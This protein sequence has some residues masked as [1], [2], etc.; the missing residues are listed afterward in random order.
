MNPLKKY[1]VVIGFS[2]I[3]AVL[4]AHGQS[5]QSDGPRIT[6]S[7]VI[8]TADEYARVKWYMGERN[9][10]GRGESSRFL[11]EYPVG[12]RTGVG[13]KWGGWDDVETFLED[14]KQGKGTGTGGYVDYQVYPMDSVS[15][16]SCTGL[17]S[18]A[19]HLEHKYTLT[20][21]NAP[22]VPRQMHEISHPIS[23]VD[24]II[25]KTDMLRKGDA[26]MNAYHIILFVYETRNGKV[27]IMD[28][29][30]SGAGFRE[31][32]WMALSQDGYSAIRYNGIEE[33][34]DPQGSAENPYS[35]DSN[36]FPFQHEGNTR[37][38]VSMEFD[39][40]DIESVGNEQGPE[41]I[42]QLD[43]KRS[44]NVIISIDKENIQG[45]DNAVYL[46]K[47]L[48]KNKNNEA[49]DV[50]AQG[51]TRIARQLNVGNY[52]IIVDSGRDRPGQYKL[53]LE[54]EK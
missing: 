52:Y 28:S 43:L 48:E 4:S 17:I 11:S 8:L 14:M 27:M 44:G 35:I 16:I 38:V 31:M 26:F 39:R 22:Q 13:Y 25:G 29:R 15:G 5:S 36:H 6:R 41:F 30:S 45:V 46:L 37:D 40:Y 2:L 18:R 50:I 21:P 47:S 3:V 54:F 20:Y 53:A 49:Q 12:N 34:D 33:V 10:K 24:F 7:Q 51:K 42:Y 9:Q 32:S 1:N 23:G 19:W